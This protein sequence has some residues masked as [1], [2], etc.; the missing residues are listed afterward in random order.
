MARRD[1]D[2]SRLMTATERE[3]DFKLR[4]DTLYLALMGE[5]FWEFQ[6]KLTTL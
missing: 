5:L 2:E 3:S 4:T 6:R 1:D